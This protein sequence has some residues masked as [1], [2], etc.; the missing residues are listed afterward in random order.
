MTNR[1]IFEGLGTRIFSKEHGITMVNKDKNV[2]REKCQFLKRLIVLE[3]VITHQHE[4]NRVLQVTHPPSTS[5]FPKPTPMA[6]YTAVSILGKLFQMC[7]E[8]KYP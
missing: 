2:T 5:L 1:K 3:A 6:F 4:I 7:A 8:K